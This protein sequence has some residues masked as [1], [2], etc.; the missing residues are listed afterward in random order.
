[1]TRGTLRIRRRT[2]YNGESYVQLIADRPATF[3]QQ[4]CRSTIEVHRGE[5]FELA[6]A[7][8]VAWLGGNPEVIECSR[9]S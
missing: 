1:M 2:R 4:A 7:A 9:G 5:S 3:K 8:L 6:K